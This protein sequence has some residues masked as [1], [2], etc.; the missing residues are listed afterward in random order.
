MTSLLQF[1]GK[2][3]KRGVGL[4]F[5]KVRVI[6]RKVILGT[7]YTTTEPVELVDC[8]ICGGQHPQLYCAYRKPADRFGQWVVFRYNG[9]EHAPNLSTPIEVE[10]IPR[11]GKAL[12]PEENSKHWHL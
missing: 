8:D 4:I 7:E 9:E 10:K 1:N 12:S 11:G 5:C 2:I 6:E 3:N